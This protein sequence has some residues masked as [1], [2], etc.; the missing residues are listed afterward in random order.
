MRIAV[1][2]G[3]LAVPHDG[4]G[5]Y[6]RQVLSHA[7][8]DDA[9][10]WWLYGR[11]ARAIAREVGAWQAAAVDR[12][13]R[14]DRKPAVRG[15]GL[16]A[17]SGRIASLFSSLPVWAGRDR[18][19]LYWG[20]AHRLPIALPSQTA[21][22]VTIHDLCWRRAPATMRRV[23]RLADAALMPSALRRADRIIAVSH[24]TRDDLVADFPDAAGRV[25]VVHEA[26]SGAT[27][28]HAPDW[29]AANAVTAP[30]VLFVGTLEPR[31]NLARLLRAFA[32]LPAA[33]ASTQL[34][35]V[36]GGGWGD[37]AL[38]RQA[39]STGIGARLRVLGQVDEA[40]L[41]TLYR[42]AACLAMPSLYEGFGLP[43][44][45]AM[46]HGTPVL[47]SN[48]ASM[49][50]VAGDAGML[51][52]PLDVASITHG[53]ERLLGDAALRARL[54]AAARARSPQFSWARAARETLA[55]FADAVAV[56]RAAS[57]RR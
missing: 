37:D 6:V 29:L 46:A 48:V 53:L 9:H 1:D 39:R 27:R 12:A 52:D 44:V 42:D 14:R 43:L 15:D 18:P 19:D 30:Y 55:V 11:D 56:R 40:A 35:V 33:L 49:P 2:A 41:A 22:V 28:P 31:K 3:A 7:M 50:E 51:V 26:A 20:P 25:V 17:A 24:A 34:V 47:T 4:I 5:R 32:Q 13:A 36:G 54:A 8:G 45:E 10:A 16:P 21:R 57:A 38:D 23:T